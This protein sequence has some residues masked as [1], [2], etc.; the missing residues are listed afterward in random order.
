MNNLEKFPDLNSVGPYKPL[1][2]AC[3][4][5]IAYLGCDP[6]AI[7]HKLQ[8]RQLETVIHPNFAMQGGSE[9]LFAF[10]RQSLQ[11]RLNKGILTLASNK[12]PRRADEFIA[13]VAFERAQPQTWLWNIISDT[14]GDYANGGR[15]DNR[16]NV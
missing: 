16:F 10:H 15:T 4:E 2:Y 3:L 7:A 8:A 14:F 1:G 11:R 5:T 6:D 13:R 9:T 12:W